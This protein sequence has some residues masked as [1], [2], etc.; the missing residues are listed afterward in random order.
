MGIDSIHTT[1][2]SK[3]SILDYMQDPNNLQ[4]YDVMIKTKD[5]SI[6]AHK[7]ILGS[8][9]DML[10]SLL[11]DT[12]SIEDA[13]IILPDYE[14][15]YIKKYLKEIYSCH[16]NSEF[17]DLN[18]S[19]ALS[20]KFLY[21]SENPQQDFLNENKT[22]STCEE[23]ISNEVSQKPNPNSNKGRKKSSKVWEHFLQDVDNRSNCVCQYCFK[24]I[25]SHKGSTSAMM[26]HLVTEHKEKLILENLTEKYRII[27]EDGI[28]CELTNLEAKENKTDVKYNLSEDGLTCLDCDKSFSTTGAARFHW[29]CVHSG[30]K[31]FS[32]H[33]CGKHFARK[34]SYTAHLI[35]HENN[36]P[37]M[38]SECGKT[39]NRKHVRDVHE[40]THAKD[41]RFSCGFC[42]RKFIN[43]Y[44]LSNHVR[45]HTG[46]R[47]YQC[48]ICSKQFTQ[49]HHL[50]THTRKHSNDKPYQCLHCEK[51]FKYLSSK[52]NHKCNPEVIT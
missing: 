38:C 43:Q 48:N 31:P 22:S 21:K 30:V 18:K 46:D 29:R 17:Q 16:N 5:G 1:A 10:K 28:S 9:S 2:L 42:E 25:V 34:E 50:V 8:I 11:L 47:P 19:F 24:V 4:D 52:R 27:T 3:S 41:F 12:N 14:T 15:S 20:Q 6:S 44:Q 40:R 23:N 26:K 7:L 35:A 33:F 39:F 13:V 32:C 37:F 45:T 36:Q 51:W 49:K